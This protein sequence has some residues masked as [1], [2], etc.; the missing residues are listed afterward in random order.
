[1]CQMH[2][3]LMPQFDLF[4]QVSDCFFSTYYKG[5]SRYNK[6]EECHLKI[7]FSD[8]ILVYLSITYKK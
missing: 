3:G 6:S 1:M 4:H 5:W 2:V 8:G 7:R